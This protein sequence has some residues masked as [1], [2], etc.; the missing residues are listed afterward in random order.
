MF[1]ENKTSI[2]Q[3]KTNKHGTDNI[4]DEI[5]SNSAHGIKTVESVQYYDTCGTCAKTFNGF[6]PGNLVS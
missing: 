5:R 1:K 3:P 4:T 6:Y 2:N